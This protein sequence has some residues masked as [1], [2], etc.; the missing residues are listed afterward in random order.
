MFFPPDLDQ[1]GMLAF[2]VPGLRAKYISTRMH[3][4]L[5]TGF[6]EGRVP[7]N[8]AGIRPTTSGKTF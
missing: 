7:P 8:P 5:T 6:E 1:E 4:D 2:T 3:S